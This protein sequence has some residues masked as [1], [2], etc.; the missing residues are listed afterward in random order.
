MRARQGSFTRFFIQSPRG[1]A[2]NPRIPALLEMEHHPP[3]PL[4]HP[5][6]QVNLHGQ[7]RLVSEYPRKEGSRQIS[8][9]LLH[10]LLQKFYH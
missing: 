10:Y 5:L 4:H 6:V 7:K 3:L 9:R 2:A 8:E 1:Y